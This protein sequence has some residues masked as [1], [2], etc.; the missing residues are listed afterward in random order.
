M[1]IPHPLD[2]R[3]SLRT[4]RMHAPSPPDVDPISPP[5]PEADPDAPPPEYDDDFAHAKPWQAIALAMIGGLVVGMLAA[6]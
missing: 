4:Q 5:T 6:R 1:T 3:N 2:W